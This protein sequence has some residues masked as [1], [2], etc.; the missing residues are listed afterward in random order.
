MGSFSNHEAI[1]CLSLLGIPDQG[2]YAKNMSA[3]KRG[4]ATVPLP[5]K[6]EVPS[7]YRKARFCSRALS[8]APTEDSGYFSTTD[9]AAG[10]TTSAPTTRSDS[11]TSLN[12]N[13]IPSVEP[14]DSKSQNSYTILQQ[15]G[16]KTSN[17]DLGN[18][19]HLYSTST[20]GDCKLNLH[21]GVKGRVK[22]V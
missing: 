17:D 6:K 21:I 14:K 3:L 20:R 15:D 13:F 2:S 9:S 12:S 7:S 16:D 19:P 10:T 4:L 8:A 11:H 5:V 22:I 1:K 18:I